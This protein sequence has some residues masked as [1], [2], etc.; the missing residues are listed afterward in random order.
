LRDWPEPKADIRTVNYERTRAV[1]MTFE[2]IG[3]AF[4][5]LFLAVMITGKN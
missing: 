3:A 2:I 4:F 5:V 1:M